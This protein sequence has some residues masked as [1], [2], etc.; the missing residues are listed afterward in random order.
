MGYNLPDEIIQKIKEYT[1]KD[2]AMSSPTAKCIQEVIDTYHDILPGIVCYSFRH[3]YFG[4]T[5]NWTPTPSTPP[6]NLIY[7]FMPRFPYS[8]ME[9]INQNI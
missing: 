5:S 3:Y 4:F 2:R 8:Y 9:T 1:P 7:H 6:K